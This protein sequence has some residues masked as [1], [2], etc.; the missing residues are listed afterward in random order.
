MSYTRLVTLALATMA[1]AAVGCGGSATHTSRSASPATSVAH[2]A[3]GEAL[4]QAELIAKADPICARAIAVISAATSVNK[5]SAIP[6]TATKAAAYAF[7]V[8]TELAVLTPPSSMVRDWR[9]IV[10]S[11]QKLARSIA[12]LGESVKR[13]GKPSAD[14]VAEFTGSQQER[15]VAAK[16]HGFKACAHP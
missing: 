10:M 3:P 9:V 12:R 8:S 5:R 16:R 6:A 13:G 11:Y 2:T 4:T 7:R 15:S 1:L 14:I